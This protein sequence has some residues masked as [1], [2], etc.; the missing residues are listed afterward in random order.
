MWGKGIYFA[1]NANYS[2]PGYSFA[3]LG[4]PRTYEVFFANAVIG[5]TTEIPSTRGLFCPPLLPGSN[6]QH[7]DSVKGHTGNS[8]VY[9][10]YKN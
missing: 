8:D 9:I 4:E 2:C 7:Y 1:V 6:D 5:N 10:V 3:A